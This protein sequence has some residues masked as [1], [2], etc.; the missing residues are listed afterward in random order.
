MKSGPT[1]AVRGFLKKMSPWWSLEFLDPDN[2]SRSPMRRVQVHVCLALML[3]SGDDGTGERV[4][5]FSQ[6]PG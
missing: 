5:A 4:T 3:Q 1:Y 6:W 2:P